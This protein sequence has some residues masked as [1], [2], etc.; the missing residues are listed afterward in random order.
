M[1]RDCILFEDLAPTTSLVNGRDCSMQLI[2][3]LL[4]QSL[5]AVGYPSFDATEATIPI[6]KVT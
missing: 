4:Y 6:I 3:L 1:E 2:A 5:V